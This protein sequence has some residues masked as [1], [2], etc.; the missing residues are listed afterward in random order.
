MRNEITLK[1]QERTTIRADLEARERINQ[2]AAQM[3]MSQEKFVGWMA[4]K[5]EAM[6]AE[7]GLSTNASTEVSTTEERQ[8]VSDEVSNRQLLQ[9][10]KS[11]KKVVYRMIRELCRITEEDVAD[12]DSGITEQTMYDDKLHHKEKYGGRYY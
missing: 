8:P 10:I 3:G 6:L 7:S 4:E 11:V 12:P 2:M 5:T 1:R 9:E